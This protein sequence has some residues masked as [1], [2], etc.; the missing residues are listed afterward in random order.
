MGRVLDAWRAARG[1][2]GWTIF[3]SDH[4]EMAGD[5]GRSSKVVFYEPSVHVP[6][7]IRPPGGS[8]KPVSCDGLV[9]LTDLSA[10][11]LD[12][13]G[14]EGSSPNVFGSTLRSVF[15]SPQGIGAS[16][17]FSEIGD[18]TMAFD[19]RWKMV[20]NSRDDVLQLFD[21][22]SDPTESLN[23]A[24]RPDTADV[25]ERLRKELLD[26]LLRTTY[27]QHREVNG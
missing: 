12:I 7:I 26:F 4:G 10:T 11:V 2:D 20:V 13:A 15:D 23:L 27:R 16:V 21:L 3:W 17:V 19:G 5:K 14:C 9:G 25:V 18:R 24:G 22:E 1:D 8:P 6:A